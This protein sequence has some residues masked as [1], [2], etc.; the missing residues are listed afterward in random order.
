MDL[1]E[2]GGRWR[3]KKSGWKRLGFGLIGIV[4]LY[5]I[6]GKLFKSSLKEYSD[7]E[8]ND[9]LSGGLNKP[10]KDYG[11]ERRVISSL[12]LEEPFVDGQSLRYVNYMNRGNLLLNRKD[13]KV[14]L[15][16]DEPQQSSSVWSLSP[17]L[18]D[19]SSFELELDF[20]IHGKS[21]RNGLYGDGMAVWFVDRQLD[22]GPVFGAENL[23]NG[24]G[25][26]IDTYKNSPPDDNKN[27]FPYVSIQLG[28]GTTPYN[29]YLDGVDTEVAGCHLKGVYNN[30]VPISKMRLIHIRES[31][32]LS[33]DFDLKGKGDWTNCVTLDNAKLPQKPYFGLSAQ[34]GQLSHNVD[35]YKAKIYSL[36]DR[37]QN[38]VISLDQLEVDQEKEIPQE[39]TAQRIRKRRNRRFARKE[40]ASPPRRSIKRL[41]NSEQRIKEKNK[42]KYGEH[43]SFFGW[44]RHVI[45]QWIKWTLYV[46]ILATGSYIAFNFYR[47]KRDAMR[48]K[49]GGGLLS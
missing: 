21:I 47:Y 20:S 12:T 13:N 19:V 24:L 14:R 3:Q 7:E 9:V 26:M 10:S 33:I 32:Y 5:L 2:D 25:V 18:E 37:D 36:I 39:D 8:L 28:D 29:K 35:V 40:K 27:K 4:L 30:R 17:I 49:R 44:L 23:F 38:P 45:L 48:G 43:G 22:S 34:T 46:S 16:S 41:Q 42:A 31:G 1:S 6:F 11:I 15:V